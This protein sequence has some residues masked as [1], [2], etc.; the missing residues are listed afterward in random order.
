MVSTLPRIDHL[1]IDVR[2]RMD[3]AEN[4]FR[5]LGF[6]LTQCSRHSL[7]SFNRLAVLE[8][9]Y[10]ELLG[11]NAQSSAVRG[12][13]AR[14][15]VGLNG[16]VF[17]MDHADSLASE[18]QSK[19]VPVEEPLAFSRTVNLPAGNREASFRV[20][21]LPAGAV[22]FGRV[23]FC[24]HLTPELVWRREWQQHA[25]GAASIRSV[26]IAVRNPRAT[27][28]VFREMFGPES[29]RE[30]SGGA[31][32]L[33]AENVRIEFVPQE[34]VGRRLG[35]AAPDPAGRDDYMAAL[36]IRVNSLSQA[37][38]ALQAGRIAGIRVEPQRI[39]VPAI[40]AMNVA[41]EFME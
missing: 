40:H 38:R 23:Y 9:D 20:V 29:L 17:A 10:L 5:S 34:E 14:F 13:I 27:G 26:T 31:W 1:V 6:Q 24:Q 16:L 8:S 7:G 25:N 3:E 19:S 36:G 21:R 28:N 22:T 15:P 30:G 39:L 2:D 37:A 41:L 33:A 11:M 18:L 35:H 4:V 32:E 12:D